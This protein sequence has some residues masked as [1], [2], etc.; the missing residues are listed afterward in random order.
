MMAHGNPHVSEFVLKDKLYCFNLF[1]QSS[2]AV[3]WEKELY[4]T[5]HV[6]ILNMS[7]RFYAVFAQIKL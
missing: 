2:M 1:I 7:S 3:N 4:S 6:E 5:K